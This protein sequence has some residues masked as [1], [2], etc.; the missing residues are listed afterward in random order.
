MWIRSTRRSQTSAK[1]VK[2]PLKIP[3][4]TSWS[5][6]PRKSN[7]LLL[8]AHSTLP[9]Y[10]I[11]IPRQFFLVLLRTD[12]R[13][14]AKHNLHG[15]GI[16]II[17]TSLSDGQPG[18]LVGANLM[19]LVECRTTEFAH[20]LLCMPMTFYCWHYEKLL[21]VCEQELDSID[22]GINAKKIILYADRCQAWEGLFKNKHTE[23]PRAWLGWWNQT[24]GCFHC[25]S[26][27]I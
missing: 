9:K 15:R 11:K 10:F 19:T 2:I 16:N 24:L 27:Q 22:M 20:L 14:K 25:A 5:G 4:F 23:W 21:W 18:S 3:G 13:T 12:E 7:R 8:V 17:A 26:K 1:V 6:S